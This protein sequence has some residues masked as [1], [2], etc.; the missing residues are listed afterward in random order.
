MK[1][2]KFSL[3]YAIPTVILF[4]VELLIALYVKDR[5]FRPYFGDFLIVIFLYCL[6]KTFFQFKPWKVALGVFIFSCFIE[7]LQAMDFIS[8]I[9]LHDSETAAILIG[10]SFSWFDML[11]Y[12]LGY[13]FVL[14]VEL[15]KK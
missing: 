3:K 8:L 2:F 6:I 14:I 4:V 1:L 13:I 9:G 10:N 12:F 5:F 11:A 7:T 15:F